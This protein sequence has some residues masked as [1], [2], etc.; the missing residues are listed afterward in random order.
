MG[1]DERVVFV[2]R[3]RGDAAV[4]DPRVPVRRPGRRGP[5]A[6]KGPKLPP[7]REAAAKADRKRRRVGEW[8]W[9]ALAVRP[10]KSTAR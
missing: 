6:Q 9:Q 10:I 3:L 5:K 4:Y 8:L 2:G 7:P 1:L